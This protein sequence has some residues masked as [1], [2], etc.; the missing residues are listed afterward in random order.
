MTA[1]TDWARYFTP[2]AA[3]RHLG[4]YCLGV[5]LQTGRSAPLETRV[6]DCYAAVLIRNGAGQLSWPDEP[7]GVQLRS[8]AMFW[9]FP[10]LSHAYAPAAQGWSELWVLFDG[11]AP[12]SYGELGY[13]NPTQPV[14]TL[15]T[16]SGVPDIFERLVECGQDLAPH[17]DVEAAALIHR[18]LV[19]AKQESIEDPESPV[20]SSLVARLQADACTP[21]TIEEH[22]RRLGVSVPLLR[23]AVRAAGGQNPKELILQ[24]RLTEAKALLAETSLPV[25]RVAQEIGYADAAYFTRL[26]TKRVGVPPRVFRQ[27][28]VRLRRVS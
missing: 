15:T 7:N 17:A 20:R 16:T 10:G 25:H 3:H 19:Q 23:D 18:L 8:P 12:R 2:T 14:Q 11:I 4:L 28:Q 6:L 22:A 26:F 24:S 9:L 13:L 27:Q 21:L 5:G 1:M